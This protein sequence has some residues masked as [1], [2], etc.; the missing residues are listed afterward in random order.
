[1]STF[2]SL[3]LGDQGPRVV[4]LQNMLSQAL[5]LKPAV[6]PT[7]NFGPL[8]HSAVVQFQTQILGLANVARAGVVDEA[9][10]NALLQEAGRHS[11][12]VAEPVP[13]GPAN[14]MIVASREMEKGV[15]EVAGAVHNEDIVKYHQSTTLGKDG[16]IVSDE[17]SWCSSFVNWCLKQVNIAGTDNAGAIS[18]VNWGNPV[19]PCYGAITVIYNKNK[20]PD[21]PGTGNHVA[22]ML[23]ET[24]TNYKLLGGNMSDSVMIKEYPKS[25]WQLKGR[26][27]PS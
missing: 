20:P 18:W 4:Q 19:D 22:F 15:H 17:T 6:P 27:W 9:T 3:K 26:R 21:S 23:D 7:G 16:K 5:D 2:K 10:W 25:G 14:W 8:T 24:D 13:V 1:M 12:L 11:P